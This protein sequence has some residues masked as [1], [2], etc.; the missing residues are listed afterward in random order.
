MIPDVR[1]DTEHSTVVVDTGK[2]VIR[3]N[4]EEFNGF[5]TQLHLNGSN[6]YAVIH[7]DNKVRLIKEYLSEHG[8]GDSEDITDYLCR[9]GEK[10]SS[11]G[12]W[13]MLKQLASDGVLEE[14]KADAPSYKVYRL[15]EGNE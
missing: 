6:N 14:I 10:T 7:Y 3:L 1:F 2:D 15:K 4:E 8:Q 11:M 12:T 9:R 5:I 13:S